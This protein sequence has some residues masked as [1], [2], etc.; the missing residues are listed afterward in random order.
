MLQI[1]GIFAGLIGLMY[2]LKMRERLVP[3]SAHFLWERVLKAG[4]RS[5]LARI[6]RRFFS[7]LLQILILVLVLLT[8]GDP[9]PKKA[10][11]KAQRTVI[12]IDE[13][14]SMKTRDMP[15]VDDEPRTR[16]QEAIRLAR[17]IVTSK[18]PRDE[19]LIVTF[20]QSPVPQSAWETEETNLLSALSRIKPRD[21]PGNLEAGLRYVSELLYKQPNSK[22]VIISDGAVPADS[23]LYWPP[24][25][26]DC[27]GVTKRVDLTGL[28]I[29]LVRVKPEAASANLAITSLAARPLPT[30]TETGEVLVRAMNFGKKSVKARIDLYVDGNW[31]ES[32][33]F[34]F[35]GGEE[36]FLLMRLPLVGTDL[37]A[38]LKA[39]DGTADPLEMDN[40]AW[41]VLPRKPEPRVLLVGRENLF[42]EAAALLVP[43]YFEKITPDEYS[44]A[45]LKNC[46]EEGGAPCN[47]VIFN[48]FVPDKVPVTQNQLY[49]NPQGGPFK[50]VSQV[51]ENLQILW[52]G[53][54][55]K[56]PIMEGVSMKD[57]N[58]WGVS[59]AFARAKG[60]VPLMQV[61]ARGTIFG[62]LHH[63]HD[64]RRLVGL[65][66]SLK[67]S[68]FVL[69][70]SFPV[71]MLNL[72]NWFMGT[73]PGFLATHPTG[74]P[75]RFSL[76]SDGITYPDGSKLEIPGRNL[77]FR[78]DYV[79]VYTFTKGKE[80]VRK[81]AASLLSQDES[82]NT[83]KPVVISCRTPGSWKA[84]HII[85]AKKH[86]MPWKTLLLLLLAGIGML[87]M[88]YLR[89]V[90]GAILAFLG[91]LT[92]GLCT[93]G[94][95]LMLGIAPWVAL[96]L[97][98]FL[99]LLL[100]WFTYNRRITV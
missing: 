90:W 92:L 27:K 3:V 78:P 49:I 81:I 88:T 89:G 71:F 10:D 64:G 7:F 73:S 16:W 20:A 61:D 55:R 5:L 6:L 50:V 34:S 36:V 15:E 45:V 58:L 39:I 26:K 31:R 21:T 63:T 93:L 12:L 2:L 4:Q 18:N 99:V 38:R 95:L 42:L 80:T 97:T 51:K 35:A 94:L 84:P 83:P 48:D 28:N 56:H 76:E 82:D 53:G 98:T 37:E 85:V 100:E 13:S 72:V 8:M 67:D 33:S 59:S 22:V 24:V 43:G 75:Q 87:I 74:I 41:A 52:T 91:I 1:F 23:G 79:G 68:D 14:A 77:T 60:D 69:Q 57:V 19:M 70:I 29:E 40:R 25:P 66:F 44:P 62:I 32:R 11:I 54:K 9:R 46:A 86:S 47:L 65:G 96:I 30:D 17:K